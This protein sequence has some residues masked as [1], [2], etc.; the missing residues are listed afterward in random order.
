MDPNEEL[1]IKIPPET[2]KM[3]T[4][5]LKQL[6]EADLPGLDETPPFADE[7]IQWIRDHCDV[8]STLPNLDELRLLITIVTMAVEEKAV[9]VMGLG[10]N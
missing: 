10:A 9:N 7:H 2:M 3:V 6:S 1:Q 5:W 8:P 4:G